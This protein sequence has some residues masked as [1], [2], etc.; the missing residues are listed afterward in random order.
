MSVT[1]LRFDS[2]YTPEDI[3]LILDD[4]IDVETAARLGVE[5]ASIVARALGLASDVISLSP[6]RTLMFAEPARTIDA[7]L[8]TLCSLIATGLPLIDAYKALPDELR[9]ASPRERACA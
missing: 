5:A 1:A 9:R 3:E 8:D 4:L 7:R 6:R 2:G